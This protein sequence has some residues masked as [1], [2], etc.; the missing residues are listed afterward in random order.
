MWGLRHPFTGA[1][2][3][4]DDVEGFVR[5][6]Q[7]DGRSGLYR[8]DGSYVEGERFDTDPQLCGWVGGPRASHRLA[9]SKAEPKVS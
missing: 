6:T 9:A 8:L 7:R 5:I 4:Q 2:Y 1:L 3:E